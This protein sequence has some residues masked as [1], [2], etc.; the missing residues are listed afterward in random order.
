MK[1]VGI[2]QSCYVPWRGYFDFI[3]SVDLFLILDDVLYSKGSW[4][5]RNQLKTPNGLKWLTVPVNVSMTQAIDQVEIARTVKPWREDHEH[6]LQNALGD[7][8]YFDTT[9][10]VW[11]E[12]AAAGDTLLSALNVRLTKLLCAKLGIATPIRLSRELGGEGSKTDR[13][14]DLL[15]KLEATH[16]LSGPS[17]RGYIDEA[18]FR[19]AGIALEYKSYDYEPYPQ[20]HGPFEGTV[21]VLDLIANTG[22]DAPRFLRSR[23]P[24]VTVVPAP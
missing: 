14:I 24:D 2:I 9:M 7:A 20:L 4:R 8:P 23:T 10:S 6:K 18:Q 15:T 5:N 17:A 13:L 16:Y 19:A 3:A 22:P 12:G 11:K 21:T 1:R